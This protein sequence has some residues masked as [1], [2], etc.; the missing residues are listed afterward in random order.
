MHASMHAPMHVT[1]CMHRAPH[2]QVEKVNP[3]EGLHAKWTRCHLS[4]ELLSPPVCIDEL[5]NLFNKD[6]V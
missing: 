4:G 3:A 5:G 6:A 2:L 1:P